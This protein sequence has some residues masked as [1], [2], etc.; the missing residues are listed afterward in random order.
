MLLL[1]SDTPISATYLA[2]HNLLNFA[3]EQ[4]QVTKYLLTSS[5][6]QLGVFLR[7]IF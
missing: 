4:Y 2:C 1:L 3:T 7:T 6:L 5:L